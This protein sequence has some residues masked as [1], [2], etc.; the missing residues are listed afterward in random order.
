MKKLFVTI[1]ALV[2]LT[3]SSGAMVNLHYCMGKLMSWDLAVESKNKCG[4]C[5]MEKSGHKSCCHD[6]HKQLK[7]ENDQRLTESSSQV[8]SIST[9]EVALQYAELPEICSSSQIVDNPTSHAPPRM[10]GVPLFIFIR[11][12]RI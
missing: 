11:N 6:E 9:Q 2:Y 3:S 12:L 7:V 10:N 1:L 8:L 4:T 5:G